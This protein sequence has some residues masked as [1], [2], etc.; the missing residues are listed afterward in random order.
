MIILNLDGSTFK[1]HRESNVDGSSALA[2]TVN[3]LLDLAN[4]EEKQKSK[5]KED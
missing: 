1:I 3:Y 4:E 5:D 2:Q